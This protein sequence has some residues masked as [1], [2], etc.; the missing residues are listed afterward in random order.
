MKVNEAKKGG[1]C[2]G[3]AKNGSCAPIPSPLLDST[4]VGSQENRQ[5]TIH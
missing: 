5:F 1:G 3:M 4:Q 2:A